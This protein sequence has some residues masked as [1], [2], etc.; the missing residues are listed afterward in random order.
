MAFDI[1]EHTDRA[2]AITP[3]DVDL[4]AFRDRPL[5]SHTIRWLQYLRNVERYTIRHLRDLLVTPSHTEPVVTE[6]LT[7]WAYQE[8]WLGET[9]DAIIAQHEPRHV[10]APGSSTVQR[11]VQEIRDRIGPVRQSLLANL[12]G[13]DFVAIHMAWAYVDAGVMSAAYRS[14]AGNGDHRQLAEIARR[15]AGLKES[16]RDFYAGQA[17]AR[18]GRSAR[19][20]TLARRTLTYLWRPPGAALHQRKETKFVLNHLFD[21]V[22]ARSLDETLDTLPGLEG[23]RIVSSAMATFGV[24]RS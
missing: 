6:F 20:R 15:A 18:L 21:A 19:A 17:V 8:F 2:S 22:E 1:R 11:A 5:G 24:I 10:S 13:E 4:A 16:H 23:L 12:I 7:G 3:D 9:L 14:A